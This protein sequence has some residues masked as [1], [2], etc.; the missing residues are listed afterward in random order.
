MH[1]RRRLE[2]VTSGQ[3]HACGPRVLRTVTLL[4]LCLPALLCSVPVIAS[5]ASDKAARVEAGTNR[6]ADSSTSKKQAEQGAAKSAFA[7]LSEVAAAKSA[8]AP[9]DESA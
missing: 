3:W 4:S 1:F 5:E 2:A 9:L 7:A 6:T 8:A